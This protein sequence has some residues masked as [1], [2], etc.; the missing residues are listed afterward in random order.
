MGDTLL[1]VNCGSSSVKL[2]LYDQRAEKLIAS[3]IAE[4]LKSADARLKIIFPRPSEQALPAPGSHQQGIEA[5]LDCFRAQHWLARAPLGIGHRVVHGGE[6][7][8][9]SALI[10]DDVLQAIENCAALAP[11]HNPA[12]LTGIAL[13]RQIFPRVPQVAVF[14]TA[15]HQTLPEY[16]YLYA[17]PYGLYQDYGVRRYGFHGTSYRHA[18]SQLARDLGKPAAETSLVCAHLGNG[19]SVAAIRNGQSVDTSMGMTPLEGLVMGTR[20]GDVDPGLFDFLKKRGFTAEQTHHML[21]HDSGLLGLSGYSND[22]R[23]LEAAQ[24]RGEKAAIR[25]IDVFC[26]RLARYIGAMLVSVN[27]PDALVFTGGIGENS[28]TVRARTLAHLQGLNFHFDNRANQDHGQAR[29]G[30]IQAEGSRRIKVIPANEELMIAAD[31]RTLI[32]AAANAEDSTQEI[33]HGD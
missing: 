22:M 32:T 2:A 31:T 29:Q 27:Q 4:N 28:A 12:N 11:L 26:F 25:A 10:D 13:L 24:D 3:A 23:T 9:A 7:F 20:S 21:N 1:V 15:F 18:L 17:L 8:T 16:A 5:C 30:E 19:C 33:R 6:S 14:D